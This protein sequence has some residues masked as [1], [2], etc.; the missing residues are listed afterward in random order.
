MTA[1]HFVVVFLLP[2]LLYII[3]GALLL[4]D[5]ILSSHV[6]LGI[7]FIGFTVNSLFLAFANWKGREWRITNYTRILLTMGFIAL[8]A[9]LFS[10]I[11]IPS[12]FTYSGC[13]AI[14][15]AFNLPFISAAFYSIDTRQY[16]NFQTLLNCFDDHLKKNPEPPKDDEVMKNITKTAINQTWKKT[17]KFFFVCI[18]FY[19]ITLVLYAVLI[20]IEAPT[21]RK[22]LGVINM[23]VI[24]ICDTIMFIW[25]L[26]KRRTLFNTPFKV[27]V[28]FLITRLIL[29]FMPTYWVIVHSFLF[30]ALLVILTTSI[31]VEKIPLGDISIKKKKE[32]AE[33]FN[34][35]PDM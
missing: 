10:V 3:W 15:F 21:N 26:M 14:F 25:G 13:S 5:D 35:Y 4:S 23:S 18:I 28:M 11:F 6:G 16:V 7:M 29:T 24:M 12:Y 20:S 34:V 19:L 22:A 8:W 31:I 1:L 30:W 32:V 33:I 2:F 9:Y 17:L 27:S